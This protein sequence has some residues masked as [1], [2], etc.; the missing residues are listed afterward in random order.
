VSERPI[1]RILVAT[2][3]S[4]WSERALEYVVRLA[5]ADL[6][7]LVIVAVLTP[8]VSELMSQR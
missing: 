2:L 8:V 6:L 7:E 1:T 3:G 4:P 5:K